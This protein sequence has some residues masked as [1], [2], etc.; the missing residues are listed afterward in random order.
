MGVR[1]ARKLKCLIKERVL[2]QVANGAFLAASFMTVWLLYMAL[3][4]ACE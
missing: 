3:Y 4:K 1:L 2:S